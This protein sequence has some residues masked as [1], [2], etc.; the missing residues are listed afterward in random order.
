M[1][2]YGPTLQPG[3]KPGIHI[4]K[5]RHTASRKYRSFLAG[6]QAY[7][8]FLMPCHNRAASMDRF[9]PKQ[10]VKQKIGLE[11]GAGLNNMITMSILNF[12]TYHQLFLSY[13]DGI[14]SPSNLR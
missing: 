13:H 2:E 7:Q 14:L 5:N 9:N 1:K 6:R 12:E 11:S 10:S 4:L 3:N 8:T